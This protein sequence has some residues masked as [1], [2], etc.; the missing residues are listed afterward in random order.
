MRIAP[1]FA[2]TVIA[3]VVPS[4][5]HSLHLLPAALLLFTATLTALLGA[6]LAV[7]WRM[8]ELRAASVVSAEAAAGWAADAPP[9]P[10]PSVDGLGAAARSSEERRVLGAPE[11]SGGE[12]ATPQHAELEMSPTAPAAV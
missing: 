3:A 7:G 1:V 10:S 4:A 2:L 9:V 5:A 6:C 11:E 8:F 12:D